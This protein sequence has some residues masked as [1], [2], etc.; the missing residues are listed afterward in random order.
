MLR[1]IVETNQCNILNQNS[2]NIIQFD[3]DFLYKC[4]GNK[5]GQN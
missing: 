1:R 2:Q 5:Q 4:N 3:M